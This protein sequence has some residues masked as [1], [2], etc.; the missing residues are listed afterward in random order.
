M[1]RVSRRL[2]C[3]APLA[4]MALASVA[5]AEDVL[6]IGYQKSGTLAVL[7]GKPELAPRLA[8][9]GVS[10][11]WV[12]F[13]S[14]PPL[15]EAINAGSIDFG[16]TGDAPP[17]FAQA[18]GGRVVYV[19]YLPSP[20]ASQ[21]ILVRKD[22]PIATV[23]DLR[24]KRV[25]VT[26]GSSAHNFLVKALAGA[27]LAYEDVEPAY[28]QPPDAAA[29]FR[30]GSVDAWAIWDPFFAQ[31]EQSG[32]VRVLITAE[33]VAPSNAFFLA[34][35]DYAGAHAAIMLAAID[36][37]DAVSR[38]SQAHQ[39]EVAA[40]IATLTGV[41][42]AAEKVALARSDYGVA[43]LTE[44]VIAQQQEIADTFHKL[45]LLPHAIEVRKAVWTPPIAA[46]G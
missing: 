6:R 37:I 31:I 7:K 4:L 10:I 25:A 38:W 40:I 32:T 28:L 36:D 9:L 20:G 33:Q 19:G 26:K 22:A 43:L 12:E 30:N 3:L 46:R 13:P 29:A 39:T 41:D 44:A 24:G 18:A 11:R 1:R 23:A 21:A 45:G 5:R 16:Y 15:L 35:R 34:A 14:G 8:A 42:L 17:I 2:C 27:A